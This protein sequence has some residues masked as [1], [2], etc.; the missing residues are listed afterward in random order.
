MPT[1]Q[2]GT[3]VDEEVYRAITNPWLY[4]EQLPGESD[5]GWKARAVMA[6]LRGRP[7]VTI[8]EEGEQS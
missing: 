7:D 6:V 2:P 8:T 4:L 5:Y 3:S 1:E